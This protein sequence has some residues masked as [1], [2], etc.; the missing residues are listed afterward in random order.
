LIATNVTVYINNVVENAHSD[1]QKSLKFLQTNGSFI[2]GSPSQSQ[3]NLVLP[4]G[5]NRQKGT[6]PFQPYISSPQTR[7]PA[8]R[9]GR[10]TRRNEIGRNIEIV[11]SQC[12]SGCESLS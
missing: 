8:K 10:F 11:G 7:P 6:V 9:S 4:G 2:H 12:F 5:S 3:T 1:C